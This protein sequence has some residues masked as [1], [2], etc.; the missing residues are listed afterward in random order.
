M[1]H[2]Q[3][4]LAKGGAVSTLVEHLIKENSNEE[5]VE[6]NVVSYYDKEAEVMA[7]KYRNLNMIWI[8]I[9]SLIKMID[10]MFFKILS[11]FLKK[12]KI[13][14]YKSIFSLFYYIK[15]SS[16]IIKNIEN[17]V[18]VLENNVLL[19]W[20]IRLSKYNKKFYYHF[21]N[22]PRFDAFN[23]KIFRKCDKFICVSKFVAKKISSSESA[24][25]KI[26]TEKIEVLYNCIDTD[27]F[28][29][30]D[31]EKVNEF[32]KKSGYEKDDFL[33]LYTGRLSEEKGVDKVIEAYKNLKNDKAK[34][35]IVGSVIHNI[36]CK[37]LYLNKLL[38]MTNDYKNRIIFTGYI[39]QNELIYYY[40]MAN[41]AVLHLCGMNQQV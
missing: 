17:D 2:T 24:I 27:L 41:V 6:F 12:K 20:I 14:S 28:Y 38:E 7:E 29:K 5:N 32:K 34:L 10:N 40:N 23:K 30:L 13:I 22:V 19:S 11:V 18:V 3:Y 37:D 35:I 39:P 15:K 25:G 8:K 21:H 16:F 4:L 9:P 1:V 26:E 33:I 36:K 31:S